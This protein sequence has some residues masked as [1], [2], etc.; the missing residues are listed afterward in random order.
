MHSLHPK[1]SAIGGQRLRNKSLERIRIGS[2]TYR[3]TICYI[4][5]RIHINSKARYSSHLLLLQSCAE[6]PVVEVTAADTEVG[7]E[8]E[9]AQVRRK[10]PSADRVDL[11]PDVGQVADGSAKSKN[12]DSGSNWLAHGK[13]QW[14][15]DQV[16]GKLDAVESGTLLGECDGLRINGSG[17]SR[18]GTVGSVA[19]GSVQCSPYRSKDVARRMQRRLLERPVLP[20]G[21][22]GWIGIS[23][24][25]QDG[26]GC[27]Y[28]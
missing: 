25:S 18:P 13:V 17:A 3:Y 2:F 1:S 24:W 6:V 21:V 27:S 12:V 20:L 23:R 19:H 22:T 10:Q 14:S 26:S 9:P 28:D 7:S 15:P 4:T 5:L 8:A 16:Q 11:A